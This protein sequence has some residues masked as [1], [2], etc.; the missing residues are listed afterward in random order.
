MKYAI[1]SLD[2][3]TGNLTALAVA[4]LLFIGGVQWQEYSDHLAEQRKAI[5]YAEKPASDWLDVQAIRV[6]DFAEGEDPLLLYEMDR[7]EKVVGEWNAMVRPVGEPTNE[8]RC[9]G[10]GQATY[11]PNVKMPDTGV[12]MSWFMGKHCNLKP[13]QYVI[14]LGITFTPDGQSVPKTEEAVSNVF[15]ILAKP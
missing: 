12:R 7:K 3:K 1:T 4:V 15:T 5:E 13:G 9:P 8:T 2:V 14:D 11:K 6:P 10:S